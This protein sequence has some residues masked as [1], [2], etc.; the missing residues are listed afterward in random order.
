MAKHNEINLMIAPAKCQHFVDGELVF[1]KYGV[2]DDDSIRPGYCVGK[3]VANTKNRK[4]VYD[5]GLMYT[6]MNSAPGEERLEDECFD[7]DMIVSS[8]QYGYIRKAK[9]VIVSMAY[10]LS[11]VLFTVPMG[12]AYCYMYMKN[13]AHAVGITFDMSDTQYVDVLRTIKKMLSTGSDKLIDISMIF[14]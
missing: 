8:W 13:S 10:G 2:F 6:S 7:I 11:K 5:F 9:H 4:H 12:T 3:I 14:E 1:S